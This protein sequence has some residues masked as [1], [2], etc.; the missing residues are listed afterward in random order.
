MV[1]IISALNRK[2]WRDLRVM[3]AQAFAIAMV[4]AAGVALYV[5]Y[6]ANFESLQ[7]ART[8]YYQRQRFGD[9]F[10][11][12]KRAPLT[13]RD[14]IESIP[15]VS[16]AELRVVTQVV[17]DLPD[18]DQPAHA[19]LVS[20]PGERRPLVN[21]LYLRRGR[22]IDP[23][24]PDEVIISEG[25]VDAHSLQ[26]GDVVVAI[27]NG[28]RRALTIA[29]VAISPEYIYVIR[30]SEMVPDDRRFAIVWMNERA[31]ASAFDMEGGFNDVTL[32]LAPGATTDEVIARVDRLLAR[33]GGVGAI[34]R[35]LQPS[36]WA[37]Q[38]ELKQL[39][40][41]GLVLPLIFLMVAAFVLNVALTRALA[42]QRAQIA[43]LKALGYSNAS[44]AWHYIKWALLIGIAGLLLGV[45]AG[46]WL[47]AV[48]GDLYN[49]YFRFPNLHFFVPARTF[50]GASGLTLAAAVAGA[51][52]AV[53][54]AVRLPPAEAMRPASPTAFKRSL[55]EAHR[56]AAHLGIV[57]RMV[58]R[59]L[60]RHRLRAA[61]SV[62]G[63]AAAFGLLLVGR[64]MEDAMNHLLDRQFWTVQ[65]HDAA[66][67]FIEPR[68]AAARAAVAHLPGVLSA[69]P[70]RVVPIRVSAGHRDRYLPLIGIDPTA[71]MNRIVDSEG[72]VLIPPPAG[73]VVSS[74]LADSLGVTR[75]GTVTVEVL[76]GERRIHHLA[77]AQTVDDVLGLSIYIEMETLHRLMG[78]D[79]VTTGALL[80]ID[81][82][83]EGQLLRDIKQSPAVAGITL[84][85]TVLQS[86]RDT[87]ASTMNTTILIN[88]IFAATIA[89]GV[90]YNAA[91]VTLS[92]RS[93]E[94]ASL[95][96]LGYTR[97]EISM[98]LLSELAVLTLVAL[99]VGWLF[100]YVLSMLIFSLV[101]SE[102]YR[103]PMYVST[104]SVAWTALAIIGA[105][106]I[107]GMA[108]RRRLD[109]LDLIAVLKVRE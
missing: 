86:F 61:V 59:N 92:E 78:E 19:R 107:S 48:V 39:E 6:L 76:E 58:L 69:E 31:L 94:L 1:M 70:Q 14:E 26:P 75:G 2:L 71:Q 68:S 102:V 101:Q 12:L 50:L 24:R 32:T 37:L 73:I 108:V 35:E 81:S 79:A 3:Q 103:F 63:I 45:A 42:L 64:V 43:S 67:A 55:L 25:F 28:T 44:L 91:R 90:V 30:P 16:A 51:Y 13:L 66:V 52:S 22:W 4:V 15:H 10:A 11:S 49:R 88:L 80:S 82:A 74:T 60:S 65:R 104:A 72:K 40:S 85:R 53:A 98:I 109:R 96:V 7:R 20:I 87:M 56:F 47:G 77:V 38:S 36:H 95:R 57:G 89:I 34:P 18:V 84:K 99:P 62:I 29:G 83:M 8:D 106:L 41:M 5:T 27:I 9:V 93:H 100:G 23:E 46:A 54:H 105:T 17:L 97:A 33:Y 21:D